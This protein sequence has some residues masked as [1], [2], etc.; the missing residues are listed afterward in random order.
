MWRVANEARSR[1]QVRVAVEARHHHVEQH[2]VGKLLG[3][4]LE[5]LLSVARFEHQVSRAL[6]LETKRPR[7]GG[8]RL[9]PPGSVACSRGRAPREGAQPMRLWGVAGTNQRNPYATHALGIGSNTLAHNLICGAKLPGAPVSAMPSFC[10]SGAEAMRFARSVAGGWALF[11]LGSRDRV[12]FHR[13]AER[14]GAR[15]SGGEE[16]RQSRVLRATPRRRASGPV[17]MPRSSIQA[18]TSAIIAA[19]SGAAARRGH[20]ERNA[21]LAARV[22]ETLRSPRLQATPPPSVER[23][24]AGSIHRRER[25]LHQGVDH[26]GLER[27]TTSATAL[28]WIRRGS[29]PDHR[30]DAR[31]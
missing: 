31:S 17:S 29:R 4:D 7:A 30:G 3:G 6:E 16:H 8:A 24:R 11:D 1:R 18:P 23:A 28:A 10:G 22:G 14:C 19:L 15:A 5:R 2:Q 9:P 27:R 12:R 20:T 26:R 13:P 25:A 21:A